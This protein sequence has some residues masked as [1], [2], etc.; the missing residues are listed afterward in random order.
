MQELGILTV[1]RTEIGQIIVANVDRARV[2]A[3]VQPDGEHLAGLIR[4]PTQQVASGRT[5]AHL[6]SRR[7][8]PTRAD[9]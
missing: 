5:S 8:E 1:V 4:K 3:L 2:A 6:V 9:G 7:A